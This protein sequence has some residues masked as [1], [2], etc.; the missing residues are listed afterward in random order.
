[1]VE[2]AAA[3]VE[4]FLLGLGLILAIGAQN[5]FVLRQGLKRAHVWTVT[6]ICFLSDAILIGAGVMGL[7]SLIRA[8]PRLIE[9]VTIG[10]AAF[11]FVYGLLALRRALHPG[12]LKAA[13]DRELSRPAAVA[14]TLA[15]TWLNPHV[16]LDTVV[17]LGSLSAR[18]GLDGRLAF[19]A[20]GTVA[21]AA[22]FY[23]LGFGARLL[24]PIFARPGAWRLFDILIG[25]VMWA[26]AGSLLA[27]L[28]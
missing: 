27:G 9:A 12:A 5:A 23:A 16:Y 2:V 14:T 4:G 10:G 15:F 21:S 28:E 1:M 20:G 25:L 24:A 3:A 22:F 17:M 8:A 26:I 13:A 6:T 19:W 11:L 18:H 7:G